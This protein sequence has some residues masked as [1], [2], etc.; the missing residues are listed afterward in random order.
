MSG[1]HRR[2][3]LSDTGVVFIFF[4]V[5]AAIAA[6]FYLMSLGSQR[7]Q[8]INSNSAP[9]FD[10]VENPVE[11]TFTSDPE[12]AQLFVNSGRRG[13]MPMTIELEAGEPISYRIV[14]S[15]PYEDYDLYKPYSGGLTPTEDVAIDVWLE[16]T[17]A[18]E[19]AAQRT[20]AEERRR[21]E[22][23]RRAAERAAAEERARQRRIENAILIV[24]NW[25]WANSSSSYDRVEGLV[26]NNTSQ[27][28]RSIV[29]EARFY[30]AND[31]FVHSDDALIDYNPLLPGQSSPFDVIVRRNPGFKLARLYF[32]TFGGQ[33]LPYVNREDIQ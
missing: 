8:R 19:Q 17:T 13:T 5:V 18:E 10:A 11:V 7:P 27:P 14:A 26:T 12:N 22:A 23:E 16:R 30:D 31:N 21:Q 3:G 4:F 32:R 25:N 28:I 1:F 33:A 15:E 6:L 2:F 24:E 9:G 20:A 29:A